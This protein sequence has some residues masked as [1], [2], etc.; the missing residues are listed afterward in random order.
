MERQSP[1]GAGKGEGMKIIGNSVIY[2][3]DYWGGWK[4]WGM[5]FN[6]KWF[7]GIS[8]VVKENDEVTRS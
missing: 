2:T 1:Q 6:C 5:W 3:G 4:L 7:C 8:K